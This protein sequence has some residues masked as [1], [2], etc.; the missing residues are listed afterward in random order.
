MTDITGTTATTAEPPIWTSRTAAAA[1]VLA[2]LVIAGDFLLYHEPGIS[3]FMFFCCLIAG[4]LALHP[5][6]LGEGRTVVL[7]VVALLGAAPFIETLSPWALL[8]AQGGLTLLA[9]GISNQLPRFEDWGG[10][11]TRFGVLAPV[12]LLTDTFRVIGEG[13]RQRAGGQLLRTIAVW[14]VPLVFA[15]IFV[16]L[17]SAANPIVEMGL[18]AIS[19]DKLLE[20]LNPSRIFIWGF[21]AVTSWPFLVPKLLT[22]VPLPQMQGPHLPRAESLVFGGIAIR[23]S[24]IVFN[25]MFALQ[26]VMDLMFLWGGV[27]LPEGM[28]HAEYAHRGAYPLIVTAILAG[29]FVLAAMRKNGPG[30]TSPLIRNL[31][32]LW[33]GQNIWLVISSLLRLKLYVEEFHLSEMRVAAGAWMVLV[34]IGLALIIARIAFGK[35]NKW[36]VMCNMAALSLTFW[37]AAVVDVRSYIAFYNVRHS[38]E[39]TG[40]GTALDLYYM[41]DLGPDAI[42]ALDELLTT[43]KVEGEQNLNMFSI[44]R[45]ELSSRVIYA[46]S[47][48]WDVHLYPQDWREW[49]WRSERLQ[50]YLLAHPFSPEPSRLID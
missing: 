43:A 21:I 3:L 40:Q 23:N 48:P 6:K 50:Q 7:F 33:I 9:L 34:A 38:Y 37:L 13:G 31:V 41:S 1:G 42:P 35:S 10:A 15:A 27:R 4:V 47:A 45:N 12:R 49:T 28:T 11:F 2:A 20:F 5:H 32:Y 8:T 16:L 39:V 18:R 46:S 19:L 30:E 17:F 22:W 24:L 36:L 29:A 14:L 44:L 25:A 26:T